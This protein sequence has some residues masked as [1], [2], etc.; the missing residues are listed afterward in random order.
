M[1]WCTDSLRSKKLKKKRRGSKG[2]KQWQKV[3]VYATSMAAGNHWLRT[4]H[5]KERWCGQ[6]LQDAHC[7]IKGTHKQLSTKDKQV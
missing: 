7:E 4:V 1:K 3:S 5:F 6:I 2:I